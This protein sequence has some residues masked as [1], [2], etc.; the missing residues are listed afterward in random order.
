MIWNFETSEISNPGLGSN[1]R[2]A[3]CLQ[4]LYVENELV[5]RFGAW[6]YNPRCGCEAKSLGNL[7]LDS[8]FSRTELPSRICGH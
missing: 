3:F 2:R 1:K 8:E 5:R 4:A 7:G 6:S